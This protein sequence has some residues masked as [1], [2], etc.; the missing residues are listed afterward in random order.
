MAIVVV[1]AP[2]VADSHHAG[3]RRNLTPTTTPTPTA[4]GRSALLAT[5]DGAR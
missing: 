4:V 2:L 5:R 1:L 3:R